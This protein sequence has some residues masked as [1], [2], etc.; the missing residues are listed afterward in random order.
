M[1]LS[2]KGKHKHNELPEC[3]GCVWGVF[4]LRPTQLPEPA[5][6]EGASQ[7]AFPDPDH[8]ALDEGREGHHVTQYQPAHWLDSDQSGAL[9]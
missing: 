4:A 3:G 8:P 6:A 7:D 1:S 5:E 2:L 9:P